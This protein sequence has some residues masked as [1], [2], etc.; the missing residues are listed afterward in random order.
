MKIQN[1]FYNLF[2]SSVNKPKTN[3]PIPPITKYD[4]NNVTKKE[5]AEYVHYL[6]KHK[7]NQTFIEPSKFV[8]EAERTEKQNFREYVHYLAKNKINRKFYC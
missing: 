4:P 7:I 1:I 6:A 3:V 2:K 5:F 8:T